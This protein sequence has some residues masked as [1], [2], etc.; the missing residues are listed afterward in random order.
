MSRSSARD[1]SL[2]LYGLLRPL[3]PAHLGWLSL[4]YN[5]YDQPNRCAAFQAYVWKACHEKVSAHDYN[6]AMEKLLRIAPWLLVA[7]RVPNP[8]ATAQVFP[9]DHYVFLT[10]RVYR[11]SPKCVL[12]VDHHFIVGIGTSMLNF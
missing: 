4:A 10:Q 1:T 12:L 6:T 2:D 8:M 9:R 7:D 5:L 11:V 3:R